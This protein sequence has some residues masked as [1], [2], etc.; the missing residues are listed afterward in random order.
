M[1]NY[2]VIKDLNVFDIIKNLNLEITSSGVYSIIGKSNSGKTLLVKTLAGFLEYS[3]SIII[4]DEDLKENKKDI[5]DNVGYLLENTDDMFITEVVR[6]EYLLEL[7]NFNYDK[8]IANGRINEVSKQLGIERLLDRNINNLSGGEKRLVSIGLLL[9]KEPSMLILDSP[10]DM[11]DSFEKDKIINILKKLGRKIPIIIFNNNLED[12]LFS[13][14]L[15]IIGDGKIK[16]SGK[17]EKILKEEKIIKEAGLELPMMADLSNKLSYYGL[18]DD[19][20]L[21]MDKMVDILW[22]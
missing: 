14:K 16:L 13:K 5:R 9:L 1:K 10:F 7:K 17:K 2:L 18:L 11:L 21:D 20:V 19:I 4:I 22:K 12:V 6:K 15:F 3:G 8:K